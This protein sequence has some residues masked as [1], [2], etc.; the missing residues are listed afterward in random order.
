M[1]PAMAARSSPSWRLKFA[2]GS[3]FSL[4][5]LPTFAR[6]IVS[7][8][9]VAPVHSMIPR[10]E[11]LVL[12]FIHISACANKCLAPESDSERPPERSVIT[13]SD[14]NS[15]LCNKTLRHPGAGERL[16]LFSRAIRRRIS[17]NKLRGTTTSSAP[18]WAR[19]VAAGSCQGY[20]LDE[21]LQPR[22]I[23]FECAT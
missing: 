21:E 22:L 23:V 20:R 13:M 7:R 9:T 5:L 17:W 16:L 12:P 15:G 1:T 14:S 3:W 8:P 11:R 2:G 4:F 10:N 18:T 6:W 19:P